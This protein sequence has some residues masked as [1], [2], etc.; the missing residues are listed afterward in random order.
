MKFIYLSHNTWI[1][2]MIYRHTVACLLTL[3]KVTLSFSK[4]SNSRECCIKW[5]NPGAERDYML[6]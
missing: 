2:E 1:K 3:K 5:N 6:F 4:L